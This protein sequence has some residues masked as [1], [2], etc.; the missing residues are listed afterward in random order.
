MMTWPCSS[1]LF[2]CSKSSSSINFLLRVGRLLMFSSFISVSSAIWSSTTL[3]IFCMT[4]LSSG[5]I[6]RAYITFL[7]EA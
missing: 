3:K 2:F 7:K 5:P 6:T 4:S 1:L